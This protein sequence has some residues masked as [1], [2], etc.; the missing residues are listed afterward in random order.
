MKNISRTKKK[1][2]LSQIPLWLMFFAVAFFILKDV[3][4]E[5]SD[6]VEYKFK[7]EGELVFSS[8]D[9]K[10]LK[11][12]N[13]EIA[14][15]EYDRQVGLMFRE[16]MDADEGMLFIFPAPDTLSFWMRNTKIS[17]DM[18]FIDS[19]KEI[20]TIHKNTRIES[21]DSYR[22]SKPSQ[23]VLEV[24]AGFTDINGIRV[25]DKVIW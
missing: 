10:L 3:Y 16:K 1:K 6:K 13:I 23:Y 20:V 24:N 17:L 12:I 14:D 4:R 11:R 15:N 19:T 8:P 5:K 9:G 18:I 7:K 22:S 25:G 21:D 2:L